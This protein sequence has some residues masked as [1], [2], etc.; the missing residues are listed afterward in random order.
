MGVPGCGK[1]SVMELAV[2]KLKEKYSVVTFGTLM[3]EILMKQ[4][5]VKTR[6][7]MRKLSD[8]V[9][10]D[11]QKQ[12]AQKIAEMAKKENVIVDTH[13]S[14]KTPKGYLIG[15]PENILK[16]I[17]PSQ[18]ILVES[19]AK[20]I[21]ERRMKDDTRARDDDSVEKID[22]Q[23]EINRILALSFCTLTGAVFTI[24]KNKTGHLLN[25]SKELA[26]VIV[27]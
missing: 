11:I 17:A 8:K 26:E 5:K 24:V 15:M 20:E 27:M 2:K 23:Q 7:E 21:Y 9:Q 13:C 22:F 19:S 18:I 16:K 10:S 25:S 12:T 3:F 1:T 14:I 4:K 6:D